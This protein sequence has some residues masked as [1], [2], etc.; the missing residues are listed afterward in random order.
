MDVNVSVLSFDTM[1]KEININVWKLIEIFRMNMLYYKIITGKG[2]EFDRLRE[3]QDGDDSSQIDWNSTARALR[4]FVKV[5]KEER[6]LDVIIVFDVSNTMLLGTTRYTKN[7]YASIVSGI[8]GYA[9]LSSG[10]KLGLIMF[11]DSIKVMLDPSL[12]MDNFYT[13]LKMFADKKNYGGMR[14]WNMIPKTLL[15]TFG[16][17]TVVFIISDFIGMGEDIF[18]D[19]N[20]MVNRFNR[21]FGMMIRD[22]IDSYLPK[23]V[24]HVYF[25]DPNTGEIA[26]VD[27]DK[28]REEYNKKAEFEERMTEKNFT[29]AGAEFI[30]V[31]TNENFVDTFV[32]YFKSAQKRVE[33]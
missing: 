2:L 33:A 1:L 17:D 32:D 31:Y 26:L 4:P 20:K 18:D 25:S 23:G 29:N 21:V 19:I 16:P 30:K 27:A 5:F 22:P 12:S 14:K 13:M 24:G 15:N 7:E 10:D 3:Y 9:A 11:S 8:L 28:I 6:M